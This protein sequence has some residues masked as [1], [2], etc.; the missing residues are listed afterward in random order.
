MFKAEKQGKMYRIPQF[1]LTLVRINPLLITCTT[2]NQF[3]IKSA[4]RGGLQI[5]YDIH[6]FK[7]HTWLAT[8]TKMK[9]SRYEI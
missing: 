8:V 4:R 2:G 5:T 6:N 3:A 9:Q 1:E 7:L